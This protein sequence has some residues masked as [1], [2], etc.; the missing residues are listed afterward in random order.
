MDSGQVFLFPD[1]TATSAT[2]GCDGP[3][4]CPLTCAKEAPS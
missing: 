4:N 1:T 3:G 2:A